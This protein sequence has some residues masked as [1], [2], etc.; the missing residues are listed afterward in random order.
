[1]TKKKIAPTKKA[2]ATARVVDQLHPIRRND[3]PEAL[4]KRAAAIHMRHTMLQAQ[5]AGNYKRQLDAMRAHIQKTRPGLQA[6]QAAMLAKQ[7]FVAALGAHHL[8]K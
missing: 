2:Q 8:Q 7:Q 6:R 4:A 1:M 3:D 5:E